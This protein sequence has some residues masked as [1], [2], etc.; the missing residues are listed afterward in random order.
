MTIVQISP[1]FGVDPEYW[2]LAVVGSDQHHM[3]GDFELITRADPPDFY[4][5]RQAAE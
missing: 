1:I 3:I 4:C 2:T 5:R